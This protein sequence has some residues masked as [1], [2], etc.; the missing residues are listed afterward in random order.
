MVAVSNAGNQAAA[1]SGAAASGTPFGVRSRVPRALP[2]NPQDGV[3]IA[4]T[5]RP[6]RRGR[7]TGVFRL[8][9]TDQAG[10]H[11]LAVP[12]DGRGR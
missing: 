5:F 6:R 3:R 12:L 1:L 7:V 2:L 9:W 4:V 8:A 11:T 10:Q